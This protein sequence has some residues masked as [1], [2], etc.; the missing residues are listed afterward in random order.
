MIES[1]GLLAYELVVELFLASGLVWAVVVVITRWL[2]VTAP[3]W[4]LRFSLLPLLLPVLVVPL[5]HLVARPFFLL[6]HSSHLEDFLSSIVTVSP[7]VATAFLG[8]A[9]LILLSVATH[10]LRPLVAVVGY[11]LGWQGH[12]HRQSH[13]WLRCNSRLQLLTSRLQLPPPRLIL[14]K[15]GSCGSF[16]LAPFGSY[17]VVSEVLVSTLDEEELESLFAHELCHIRRKDTLFGITVGIC[18]RL[19]SFSPFARSAYRSF[20]RA[21]EEL[22]DDLAIYA[23]GR[24]LALA[25]CLVK[26]YRIRQGHGNNEPVTAFAP[27]INAAESRIRRLLDNTTG[28]APPRSYGWTFFGV[29]A[30]VFA[31]LLLTI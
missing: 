24:P 30:A 11:R 18:Y 19:L 28:T 16:A 23:V 7:L 6:L 25:S 9:G 3:A 27:S 26:A 21:R 4:R 2:N 1:W 12:Y 10:I 20:C 29:I 13:L 17:I 5:I 8:V 22:V 14:R 15:D 31:I